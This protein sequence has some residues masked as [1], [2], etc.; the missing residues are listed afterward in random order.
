[1]K[2]NNID[3]FIKIESLMDSDL[4]KIDKVKLLE[5][6]KNDIFKVEVKDN[7]FHESEARMKQ[8]II[9][10]LEAFLKN[11][12]VELIEKAKTIINEISKH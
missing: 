1:M 4:N 9:T 3:L 10:D 5:K 8:I 11:G 7:Y 12:N 6:I 2:Y